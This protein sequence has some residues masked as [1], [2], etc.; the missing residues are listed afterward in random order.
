MTTNRQVYR[1]SGNV[2]LP[3]F[4][5]WA[6]GALATSVLLAI[7][8]NFIY[9]KGHYYVVIVPLLA[10][11]LLGIPLSLAISRGRCRH[12]LLSIGLG[13]AGGIL[14]YVGQFYVG[15]LSDVGLAQWRR[16]DLLPKYIA[17]RLKT[18]IESDVGKKEEAPSPHRNVFRFFLEF[19]FVLWLTTTVTYHRSRRPFCEGCGTWMKRDLF[20]FPSGS[21]SRLVDALN[22]GVLSPFA[23]SAVFPAPLSDSTVVL[24]MDHC[25][26]DGKVGLNCPAYFSVKEI[27]SFNRAPGF[28]PF[29]TAKGKLL[30]FL[31][32]S[33]PSETSAFLALTKTNPGTGAV[34]HHKEGQR[35]GSIEIQRLPEGGLI[36]THATKIINLLMVLAFPV[37]I[38]LGVGMVFWGVSIIRNSGG[39]SNGVSL[40]LGGGLCLA[41]AV[42][43]VVVSAIGLQNP[44]AV[45]NRI[46]CRKFR[47]AIERRP[48]RWVD[49][50]PDIVLVE[51]TPRDRW[52]SVALD[53][54]AD[55]GF[56]RY[57]PLKKEIRFEGDHERW[58]IPVASIV[59]C[60][61]E[62]LHLQNIAISFLVLQIVLPE[63]RRELPLSLRPTHLFKGRGASA[64]WA[65]ALSEQINKDRSLVGNRQPY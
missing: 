35:I 1:P 47:R 8:L 53:T 44:S 39:A 36:Y 65:T 29:Q 58:R 16:T 32:L 10:A 25:V 59:E 34:H 12:V 11:M 21:G 26:K 46:L 4:L 64:A 45:V 24:A 9:L 57:D 43:A 28:D 27:N 5:V 22:H 7:L 18:D 23:A 30:A 40:V 48:D 31:W 41:G 51:Y 37:G 52:V 2:D 15:F 6:I 49:T 17:Y 19:S 50:G 14:L 60:R 56:L 3:S 63:G 61:E 62:K 55:V 33:H 38:A 54:A 42:T 13:L 20:G